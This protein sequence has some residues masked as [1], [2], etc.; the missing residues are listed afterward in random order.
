MFVKKHLACNSIVLYGIKLNIQER[1]IA[2]CLYILL[3][4]LVNNN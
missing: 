4:V 3:C 2:L 1:N